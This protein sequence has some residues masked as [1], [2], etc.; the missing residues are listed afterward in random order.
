MEKFKHTQFKGLRS[1]AA[2]ALFLLFASTAFAQTT[3]T[4]TT[5]SGDT[6]E[7]IVGNK[8]IVITV[9]SASGKKDVQV[10]TI[11]KKTSEQF[12]NADENGEN[13]T[14][15]K[16]SDKK[17]IKTVDVEF[18]NMDLGM[19]FAFVGKDSLGKQLPYDSEPL[20]S[21]HVG[22]HFFKT[23]INFF[24]GHVGLV[25][26]LDLDNN[27]FQFRDNIT[28]LPNK[29]EVTV[30][31]DSIDFRKNKLITWHAQIPLLLSFQTNPSNP[32]KNFHISVGGFAGLL[33][34]ASTKQKSAEN[35]KV[36]K[37]DDF[38][39]N[40]FRYG[41]TARVGYRGLELYSNY[42]LTP[43]F[44]DSPVDDMKTINFGISLT[45]LM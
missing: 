25:T 23:R 19:N 31:Y 12:A 44:K 30:R 45:G 3:T 11:E 22:L 20:R 34:A 6:T 26:A 7:V 32:K 15:D 41:L 28:L 4:T 24:K 29:S 27:R 42:T 38:N 13:D 36:K 17:E 37:D 9:D 10:R 16:D 1:L 21:T 5:T 14:P 35:G 39:V 43:F 8:I 40:P 33:I 2:L 18:F